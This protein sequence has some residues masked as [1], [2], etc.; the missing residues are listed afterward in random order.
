[1]AADGQLHAT[2][3]AGF[4]A[5]VGQPKDFL[6]GQGLYLKS[7]AAHSP[8]SLASGPQFTGNVFV[9]P[10]AKIGNGCKIGPNV[11]IGPDVIIGDG[12]RLQKANIMRSG[13]VKDNAW[14]N[15]S[16]VG[17]YSSVGRWV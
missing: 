12:V 13:V 15:N 4:W 5:D 10:T 11:V 3:L 16:I 1:M 2:P 8:K 9:D 17:W 7:L 6:I 14:I